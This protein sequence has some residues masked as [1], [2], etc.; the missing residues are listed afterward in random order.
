MAIEPTEVIW[1]DGRFVPWDQ[2]NV[3][4]SAHALHYGSSV[5]EGIRAYDTDGTASIFCLDAHIR[6]LFDSC[7]VYRMPIPFTAGELKQACIDTV[8]NNGLKSAYIRPLVFRGTGA[9]GV[10]PRANKVHVGIFTIYM[11]AYLGPEA[12]AQGV[13]V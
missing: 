6:R 3:H 11:G 12:L 7:K 1:L 8:K 4:L 9:I 2:A 10:D 13:D 5:F